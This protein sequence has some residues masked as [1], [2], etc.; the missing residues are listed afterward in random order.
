MACTLSP[1][2]SVDACSCY[3]YEQAKKSLP[4]ITIKQPFASL[5]G[6]GVKTIEV[7]SS[8]LNYRGPLI[9]C[10]GKKVFDGVSLL[11]PNSLE[12]YRQ[13]KSIMPQGQAIAVVELVDC[14]PMKPKDADL[15]FVPYSEG[16]YSW[17][18]RDATSIEPFEVSGN[19]GIFHLKQ[20]RIVFRHF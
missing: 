7:R 14:R 17:I 13:Y 18:L 1:L 9:I 15:S 10:S 2:L 19:I 12:Y 5:V 8:N 4:A 20:N 16:L 11:M 6:W 3:E